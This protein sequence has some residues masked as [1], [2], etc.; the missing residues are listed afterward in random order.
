M[1]FHSQNGNGGAIILPP[2]P[3]VISGRSLA[4]RQWD[5]RQR[6]CLAADV[7]EGLTTITPTQIQVAALLGVSPA[8]VQIAHKLDPGKRA[9]IQRGWDSTSFATLTSR[10]KILALPA[11][12]IDQ[13]DLENLIRVVGV[14][15][16]LEAAAAVE[17][18]R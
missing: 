18:V 9:A 1:G 11:P 15:R 16:A 10:R 7:I 2:T 12:D 8:Y 6:A 13:T 3:K 14:D 17:S 5:K 4:H